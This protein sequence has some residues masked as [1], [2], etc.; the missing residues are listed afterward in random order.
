[1]REVLTFHFNLS[2]QERNA[3]ILR[4]LDVVGLER[5]KASAKP[6]ALSG[7]ER[8]RLAIARS[9]AARPSLLIL[10]EAVAS[11]DVSIQAQILN[12]L[13]DIRSSSNLA[14]IFI[15]HD[16]GVVRSVSESV[17]VMLKGRVIEA[18]PTAQVLDAPQHEYSR[19]LVESVPRPGWIPKR[20]ARRFHARLTA[21]HNE[22]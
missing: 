12:L 20:T 14:Y 11:L 1:L 15:S 21:D 10:D 9:L 4:L 6:S 5:H 19:L 18:G 22:V 13:I 16:L 2:R 8:Q 17:L 3:E 7:G